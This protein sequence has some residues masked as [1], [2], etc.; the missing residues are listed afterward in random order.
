MAINGVLWSFNLDIPAQ[1]DVRY[2]DPY[3][4]A[5]Y[6]FKGFRLGIKPEDHALGKTLRAGTPRPPAP[7]K[8]SGANSTK[9]KQ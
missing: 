1:T 9:K 3:V 5:P 2:I 8:A 7:P 6:A 4:P